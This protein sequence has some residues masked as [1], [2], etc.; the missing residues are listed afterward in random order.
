MSFNNQLIAHR[1]WQRNYP[2]NSLEGIEAAIDAGAYHVEI[3]IQL[4]AD[5][6]AVLFHDRSLRRLCGVDGDIFKLTYE[7]LAEFS[8]GEPGR[9]GSRFPETPI[10]LLSDLVAL[11]AR[12]PEVTLYV[13]IKRESLER[14]GIDI[15]LEAVLPHL[16]NLHQ[17]CYVISFDIPVLEAAR[18][19]G[20]SLIAP[21]LESLSQLDNES[22]KQLAPDI[23]FCD[24]KL[25]SDIEAK[26]PSIQA[27]AALWPLAVYEIDQYDQARSLLQQGIALVETFAIGELMAAHREAADG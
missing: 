2:E 18:R 26:A 12:H 24:H 22:M 25:L 1:G 21:V 11:I 20:W 5:H 17:R 19:V 10:S 3:D 16:Q 7:Q 6:S 15:V 27:I 9:L 13:E 8:A 23:V 14:F 4:T